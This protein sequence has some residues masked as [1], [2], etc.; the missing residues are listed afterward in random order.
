MVSAHARAHRMAAEELALEGTRL[1]VVPDSL[2]RQVQ[3]LLGVTET[4][5]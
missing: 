4:G 3:E 5:A 2:L 1:G